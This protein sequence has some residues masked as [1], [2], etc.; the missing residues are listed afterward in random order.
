MSIEFQVWLCFRDFY[1]LSSHQQLSSLRGFDGCN[2]S[3]RGLLFLSLVTSHSLMSFVVVA[4]FYLLLPRWVVAHLSLGCFSSVVVNFGVSCM[5]F[6]CKW[7]V[8]GPILTL[9][10]SS[11]LF[12]LATTR[13][14]VISLVSS[15]LTY[16]ALGFVGRFARFSF[17]DLLQ[18]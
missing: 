17:A 6:S 13:L 18:A 7:G 3:C 8:Q 15:P 1:K 14:L 11:C 10:P 2:L 12:V 9:F 4:S 16:V 5:C